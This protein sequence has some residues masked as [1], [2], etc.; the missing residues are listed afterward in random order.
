MLAGLIEA[1]RNRRGLSTDELVRAAYM[2]YKVPMPASPIG[3]IRVL[4]SNNRKKL[5][6]LGWEILGPSIT[7]NGFWLVPVEDS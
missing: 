6:K 4:I 5:R 1:R 2:N 7:K 3:T